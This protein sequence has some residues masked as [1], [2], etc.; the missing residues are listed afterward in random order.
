MFLSGKPRDFLGDSFE[1]L[2]ISLFLGYLLFHN[3]IAIGDVVI[4]RSNRQGIFLWDY[5]VVDNATGSESQKREMI[6]KQ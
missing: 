4:L 5:D 1:I 2:G 3:C 6:G